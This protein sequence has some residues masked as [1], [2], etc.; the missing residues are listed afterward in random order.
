MMQYLVAG[1]PKRPGQKHKLYA[2]KD[3]QK[4]ATKTMMVRAALQRIFIDPATRIRTA[5][6]VRPQ[7]GP[8]RHAKQAL[9]GRVFAFQPNE[10]LC[11]CKRRCHEFYNDA[12]ASAVQAARI[13]LF[14]AT[15]SRDDLR[16]QLTANWK[17]RTLPDGLPICLSMACRIFVCSRSKMYLN[18]RARRD[19][20]AANTGTSEKAVSVM[21]WF[22]DVKSL[23]D[24]MPDQGGVVPTQSSKESARVPAVLDGRPD[25][26]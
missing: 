11:C 14:D 4:H 9:N 1:T 15:L 18:K 2:S 26:Q 3:G 5:V 25:E 24:I 7:A 17:Q 8:L 19:R 22:N 23:C 21:A 13:P 16:G 20:A 6:G 10:D 12:S